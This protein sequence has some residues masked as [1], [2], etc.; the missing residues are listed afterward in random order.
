ML[1]SVEQVIRAFGQGQTLNAASQSKHNQVQN[2]LGTCML[3]LIA[4]KH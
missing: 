1:G 2:Q 4:A 3:L